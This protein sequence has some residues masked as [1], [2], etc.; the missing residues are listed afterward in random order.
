MNPTY[1]PLVNLQST[2]AFIPSHSKM[3]H[4]C[5]PGSHSYIVCIVIAGGSLS[6]ILHKCRNNSES[7]HLILVWQILPG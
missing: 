2:P 3:A 7:G 6:T 1:A 4:L 5:R